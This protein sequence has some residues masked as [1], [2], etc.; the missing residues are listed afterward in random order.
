VEPEQAFKDL[1]VDSLAAVELRNRLNS[2]TGLR[3]PATLVFD[4][5]N[6]AAVAKYLYAQMRGDQR[7][8]DREAAIRRAIASIPLARLSDGGLLAPLLELAG[9]LDQRPGDGLQRDGEDGADV[10]DGLDVEDL[11]QRAL[12]PGVVVGGG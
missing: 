2:A 6:A 12:D 4:H 9:S 11:V 10:V 5:P 7:G 8:E 3:L 1:G